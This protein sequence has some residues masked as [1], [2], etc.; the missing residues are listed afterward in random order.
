MQTT[1]TTITAAAELYIARR[2]RHAHPDGHT[3][4]GGRWYPSDT[5]DCGVT[6]TIRSPSRAWPWS[7]MAACRT[8]AHV[9]ALCG[10]DATA[11]RREAREIDRA[12]KLALAA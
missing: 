1:P 7:Y 3:D 9:A 8:A 6:N 5:E 10:V 12:K 4:N 11:L 2:D